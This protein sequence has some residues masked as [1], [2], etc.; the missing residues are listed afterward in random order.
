MAI[1]I[2]LSSNPLPAL[3]LLERESEKTLSTIGLSLRNWACSSY[4]GWNQDWK[5]NPLVESLS[6]KLEELLLSKGE[7]SNEMTEGG[8]REVGEVWLT[9]EGGVCEKLVWIVPSRSG[10]FWKSFFPWSGGV[11]LLIGCLGAR[12]RGLGRSTSSWSLL[13]P[14]PWYSA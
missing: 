6:I 12:S 10:W 7:D 8:S 14:L 4:R 11:W 1:T 3:Q 9:G 13:P 2:Q 5:L